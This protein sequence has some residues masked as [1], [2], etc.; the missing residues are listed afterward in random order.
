MNLLA[1]LAS[2]RV[3]QLETH[4][5]QLMARLDASR[6]EAL[7]WRQAARTAAAELTTVRSLAAR[8]EELAAD[9]QR[10]EDRLA[11]SSAE[12]IELRR[13][14]TRLRHDLD[15]ARKT[16]LRYEDLLAE[17]RDAEHPPVPK[18]HPNHPAQPR[19]TGSAGLAK[20]MNR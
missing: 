10:V 6:G 16:L 11:A 7:A 3:R 19:T 2:P 13:D 4:G 14:N 5:R 1:R 17:R 12:L 18:H 15:L 20:V 9:A 8:D